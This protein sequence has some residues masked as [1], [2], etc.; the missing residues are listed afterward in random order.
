M[1]SDRL[2]GRT[3]VV[4]GGC[5]GIGLATV[6]RFAAE[7]AHVVIADVD[8]ARGKEIADEVRGLFVDCDVTDSEQ[9]SALYA[10]AH[11]HFEIALLTMLV[12]LPTRAPARARLAPPPGSLRGRL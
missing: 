1:A 5:S 6:R 3:A 10:A 12:S 8:T 11:D 7:G 4:T 9:V 2:K